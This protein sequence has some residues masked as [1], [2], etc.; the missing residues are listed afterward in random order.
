MKHKE[1]N[2]DVLE[3]RCKYLREPGLWETARTLGCF[4]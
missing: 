1:I 3:T 2:G 4:E